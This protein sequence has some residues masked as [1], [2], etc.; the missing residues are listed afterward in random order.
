MWGIWEGHRPGQQ[1]Q[2]SRARTAYSH[3]WA[4]FRTAKMQTS[5]VSGSAFGSSQRKNGPKNL[6]VRGTENAS[7][8]K[9]KTTVIHATS[10]SQRKSASRC[11]DIGPSQTARTHWQ[12]LFQTSS[13]GR[14]KPPRN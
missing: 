6:D 5:I 14:A 10:G 13:R 4:I 11:F 3:A 12:K 2:A 9:R 7:E 8:E 1:G